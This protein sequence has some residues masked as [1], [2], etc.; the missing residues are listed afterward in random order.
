MDFLATQ[1]RR[2]EAIERLQALRDQLPPAEI[3][4]HDTG[5]AIIAGR[6]HGQR[7]YPVALGSDL[8]AYQH[9]RSVSS[10]RSR[11]GKLPLILVIRLPAEGIAA[12]V[13]VEG[14]QLLA[15]GMPIRIVRWP[16][17]VSHL[18]SPHADL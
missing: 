16:Y 8:N 6:R 14:D 18:A 9:V 12:E 15:R 5:T 11:K 4:R 1:E 13:Q 10:A 17:Q 2:R 3:A 7:A